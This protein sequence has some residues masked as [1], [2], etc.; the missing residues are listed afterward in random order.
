MTQSKLLKTDLFGEVRL[1]SGAEGDMI[2]RDTNSASVWV[3]WLA[4]A[5]MRREARIL[6]LLDH[7]PAV[8][9]LIDLDHSCLRR[10][11]LAGEPMQ[12]AK[13]TDPAYF[14]EAARLLRK[15][16]HAGVAHNDL[17]KEPNLLVMDD[18]RPAFL[19]FQLASI[20]R[21]RSRVFRTLAYDDIRHLLKHKRN[22]CPQALSRRERRILAN[23]SLLAKIWMRT[24]KPVYLFV[25]RRVL[26]WSD[27]EGAV[28]R[29]QV[30]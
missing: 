3:R 23:P 12:V 17:A 2:V 9:A 18:S 26:G 16:H 1:I 28:N 29:G 22:Y 11:F 24:V 6:A 15:L 25:T 4:R 14:K 7:L 19:D 21:R 5:M 27:R 10:Q 20:S 8:P 13:P 30:D